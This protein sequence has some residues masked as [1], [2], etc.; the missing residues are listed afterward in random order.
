MSRMTTTSEVAAP[1]TKV[2]ATQRANQ[3]KETPQRANQKE[4]TKVEIGHYVL[5]P[6]CYA[7]RADEPRSRGRDHFAEWQLL[8]TCG[9]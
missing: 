7:P 3:K 2:K 6:R 5:S 4:E 1:E 9:Y 8:P